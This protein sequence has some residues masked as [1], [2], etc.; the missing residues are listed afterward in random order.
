MLALVWGMPLVRASL[1]QLDFGATNSPVWPGFTRVTESDP[2]LSA[3]N[4]LVSFWRGTPDDLAGD[5]VVALK[6]GFDVSLPLTN[7]DYRVWVLS[8]DS[9]NGGN[10]AIKHLLQKVTIHAN[11]REVYQHPRDY[12]YAET[13]DYEP[14]ADV[15]QRYAGT[16]RFLEAQFNVR[17]EG[18]GLKLHFNGE[19]APT[20]DYAFPLNALIIS[21]VGEADAMANRLEEIRGERRR[22]W[23]ALFPQLKTP[24]PDRIWQPASTA[25]A[26][27]YT[28]WWHEYLDKVYPNTVPEPGTPEVAST[29]AALGEW[30][31]VTF[32]VRPVTNLTRVNVTV[33]DLRSSTSTISAHHV[34]PYLVR[35]NESVLRSGM[36]YPAEPWA[37]VPWGE[38]G[39]PSNVTR[40]CW[41]KIEVPTN[42][43]PGNYSG[44]VTLR[45]A[46]AE[47]TTLDYH[48]QVLPFGLERSTNANFFYFGSRSRIE[49]DLTGRSWLNNPAWWRL[50]DAESSNLVAHG[51][52]PVPEL[53]V[54]PP[55]AQ[56]VD[57]GVWLEHGTNLARLDW[58]AATR[59][60]NWM[61]ERG[62]LPPDRMWVVRC[63]EFLTLCG[64]RWQ[65]GPW[66]NPA[67]GY[68][69]LF[70]T[71]VRAVDRHVR[72]AGWGVPVFEWGGELSNFAGSSLESAVSAHQALRSCDV[73]T[74][75]RGNGWADWSLVATNRL[76]DFPI[77][78]IALL[79]DA[80]TKA[81]TRDCRGLWLY[82][83]TGARYGY[84][85]F[86]W[87]K[88]AT[89][90]L[91]EGH[92]D[93]QGAPWDNFDGDHYHWQR[94]VEATRDGVAALVS[95]EWMSEGRDDFDY[96]HTLETRL[97]RGGS[98]QAQDRA[99]RTLAYLRSRCATDV[100][101][102]E[103][104]EEPGS[105]EDL[106][107]WRDLQTWRWLVASAILEWT[108]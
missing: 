106:V 45:P 97:A 11:G 92:L 63:D 55:G 5:G 87:A 33:S 21:P 16:N 15:W 8:G 19:T 43:V 105:V 48:L 41:L 3:T 51:F 102:S 64:G 83:F 26:A 28:A 101:P 85:F 25:L 10:S 57:V 36:W 80:Q 52:V 72:E 81:V 42:A 38:P 20:S 93:T 7:G 1:V 79:R 13:F 4:R 96:V 24:S 90:C 75:H 94:G 66:W 40:Q 98:P 56:G 71:I 60:V 12:W 62:Y 53:R 32:C 88:G 23:L 18:Q 104:P 84:G 86:A 69:N 73:L 17:V 31:P 78:N 91:H 70:C 49:S 76:V 35:Y 58:A 9:V 44:Q 29:F 37:L 14:Q 95:L 27:G 100:A 22:Q 54:G 74:A 6:G 34:H 107:A 59:R 61:A 82:N 39:M 50:Y 2:M 47:S 77:C 108:P 68:S 89:R 65:P 67:S 46:N 30:E 103:R 99:R